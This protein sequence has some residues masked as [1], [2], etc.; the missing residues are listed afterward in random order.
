MHFFGEIML[1]CL[2]LLTRLENC[3]FT[4]LLS[5]LGHENMLGKPRGNAKI[6][7]SVL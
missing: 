6:C 2:E 5:G 7:G 1:I 3:K 4:F